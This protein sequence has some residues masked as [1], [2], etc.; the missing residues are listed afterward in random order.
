MAHQRMYV[1]QFKYA[2]Y[3]QGR[4]GLD[5]FLEQLAGDAKVAMTWR[6]VI[7][8]SHAPASDYRI[9]PTQPSPFS[10]QTRAST[11]NL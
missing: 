5:S 11:E 3:L 6:H 9:P 7:G 1:S 8:T 2:G 10:V 4:M